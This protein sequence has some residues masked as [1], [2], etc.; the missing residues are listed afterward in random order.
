MCPSPCELSV[1]SAQDKHHIARHLGS[2]FHSY[3]HL[4]DLPQ[5]PV[6]DPR[7]RGR[8]WL[9][10]YHDTARTM[11]LTSRPAQLGALLALLVYIIG[12]DRLAR[13]ATSVVQSQLPL[14]ARQQ[15]LFALILGPPMLSTARTAA[16][17]ATVVS[18]GV[19]FKQFLR[20]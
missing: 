14:E 3:E 16:G 1:F 11:P 20:V 12:R 10:D 13:Q 2:G 9:M 8:T 15:A 7:T 6:D 18:N 4:L 17:Q 5:L 19:Q